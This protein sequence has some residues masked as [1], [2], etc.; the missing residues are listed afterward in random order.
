MPE[1]L[2]EGSAIARKKH[3]CEVTGLMVEPGER[4]HF[5]ISVDDEFYVWKTS[6]FGQWLFR[7]YFKPRDWPDGMTGQ[8]VFDSAL[9]EFGSI[10]EARE[11][12]EKTKE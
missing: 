5:Q 10:E 6:E 1:I 3:R 7:R 9:E 8:D 4:Y 2:R 12:W 11:E